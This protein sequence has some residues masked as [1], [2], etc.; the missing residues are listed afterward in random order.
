MRGEIMGYF[1]GCKMPETMPNNQTSDITDLLERV[2]KRAMEVINERY[3]YV[4]DLMGDTPVVIDPYGHYS[5]E[6]NTVWLLLLSRVQDNKELYARL[7]YLRGVGTK[8][9]QDRTWGYVM[10]PVIGK[11]GWAS[12]DEYDREKMCL[13]GYRDEVIRLLGALGS[14]PLAD[15]GWNK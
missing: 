4:V 1:E 5:R 14:L 15:M 7:F 10:R 12:R 6:D 13:E 3:P 8:L 11:Q 2:E 9:V